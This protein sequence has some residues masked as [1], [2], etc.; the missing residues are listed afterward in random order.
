MA[1]AMPARNYDTKPLG[2]DMFSKM[3]F[4]CKTPTLSPFD[5]TC[6]EDIFY[7]ETIDL[8]KDEITDYFSKNGGKCSESKENK[9]VINCNIYVYL[10]VIESYVFAPDKEVGFDA[11]DL[12]HTIHFDKNSVSSVNISA[13]YRDKII[14]IKGQETKIGEDYGKR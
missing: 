13:K 9:Y 2:K 1:M 8:S 5:D 10:K 12:F 14:E 7:D 3:I 11:F 4:R 6:A